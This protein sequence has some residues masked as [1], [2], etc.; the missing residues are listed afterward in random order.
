VVLL[1]V[2]RSAF[3]APDTPEHAI[4]RKNKT[5][6]QIEIGWLFLFAPVFLAVTKC[7]T[8][9]ILFHDLIFLT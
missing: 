9:G 5:Q 1:L 2:S 4:S 3:P 8:E 6:H 7:L